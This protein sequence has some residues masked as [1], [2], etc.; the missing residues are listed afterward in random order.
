MVK[1]H[2]H[3]KEA[4]NTHCHPVWHQVAFVEDEHDLLMGLLLLDILQ[5]GL[6]HRPKR[7]SCIKNMEDDI[8]RVDNFVQFAIDTS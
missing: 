2:E 1:T 5:N 7:V 8:R 6:A 4:M 3:R